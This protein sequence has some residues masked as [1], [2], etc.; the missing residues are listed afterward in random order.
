MSAQAE[1]TDQ[2]W[3]GRTGSNRAYDVDDLPIL[4]GTGLSASHAAALVLALYI[5]SD[6]VQVLYSNPERLWLVVPILLYWL[7]R[8]VM[9][10]HRGLMNDDP[11]VFA[12]TD[13]VSVVIVAACAIVGLIAYL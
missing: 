1:L 2:L 12:V 5:S 7:L 13:R 3:S 4:R 11:I 8:M 10:A 6:D 9:K